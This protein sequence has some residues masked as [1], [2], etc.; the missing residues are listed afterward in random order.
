MAW[1][2][3]RCERNVNA[4]MAALFCFMSALA[5]IADIRQGNRHVRFGSKAG[6]GV[7]AIGP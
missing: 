6:I 2:F 1:A 5:P 4:A 7:E 3:S